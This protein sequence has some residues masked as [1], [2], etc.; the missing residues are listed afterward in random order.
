[1]ESG[2]DSDAPEELTAGE[3]IRQHEEI[4]KTQRDNVMRA[5]KEGKERRRQWAQKRTVAKSEKKRDEAISNTETGDD[6]LEQEPE[7]KRVVPGMLPK[8][9][10]DILAAREKQ[11]FSS[12]SEEEV[13]DKKGAAKKKM[14]KKRRESN[15]PETVVLSDMPPPQCLKNSIDFL[16]RRKMQTPRSNSILKNADRAL[17]LLS[18]KGGLLGKS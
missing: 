12:D 6:H 1:M 8:D 18:S 3:G 5:A 15:G 2:S 16:K 10:V 9:I 11:T 7:E 14:N 13:V 17:C 4:R